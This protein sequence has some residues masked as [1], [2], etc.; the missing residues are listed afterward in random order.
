MVH[1][2]IR[3]LI[4]PKRRGEV[5]EILSSL[6]ERSRFEAG[7]TGSRVYQDVEV[8]PAILIEQL[9]KSGEDLDRYLRSEEFR[10]VLLVIEMAV[11]APE[12]RFDA[13][14]NS[15]GLETIEKARNQAR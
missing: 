9:W 2:T 11:E 4:P 6:A 8:E 13:I 14:S 1:A 12:I 7:C 10:K 15:T 3:M 5:M